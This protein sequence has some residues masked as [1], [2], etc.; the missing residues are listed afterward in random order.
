MATDTNDSGVLLGQ[1]K[2]VVAIIGVA[3]VPGHKF[4]CRMASLQIFAWNAHSAVGLRTGRINDLVIVLAEV[5]QDD[6]FAK[7]NIAIKPKMGMTGD[8]IEEFGNGFDLLMIGG[9]T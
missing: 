1:I 5:S 3:V 6:V 8:S 7:F 4:S 2:Y 9:N